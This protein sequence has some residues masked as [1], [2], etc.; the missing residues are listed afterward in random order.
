MTG[1]HIRWGMTN[2]PQPVLQPQLMLCFYLPDTASCRAVFVTYN[3][4]EDVCL[5]CF[6]LTH[7]ARICHVPVKTFYFFSSYS[8]VIIV[9]HAFIIRIV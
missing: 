7:C 9:F 5:L 3:Y 1:V 4:F 2:A 8:V 6:S